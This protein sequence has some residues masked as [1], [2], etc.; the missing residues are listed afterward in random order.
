MNHE[1]KDK[2]VY[3]RGEPETCKVDI[4]EDKFSVLLG[5]PYL[6]ERERNGSVK[7]L[8]LFGILFDQRIAPSENTS[9]FGILGYLYRWN[10]HADG[11]REQLIFPF[12]RTATNATTDTWCFSFCGRLFKVERLPDGKTEWALFWL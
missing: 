5:I 4:Y 2:R 12:I 11:T 8:S 1:L 3:E 10:R 6:S 7:R 9:T